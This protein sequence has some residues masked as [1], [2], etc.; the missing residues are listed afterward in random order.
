MQV[1][2]TCG[3]VGGVC[4]PDGTLTHFLHTNLYSAILV[5]ADLRV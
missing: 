1:A 2:E 4:N 3:H 5:V